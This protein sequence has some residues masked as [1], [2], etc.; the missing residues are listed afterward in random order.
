MGFYIQYSC[1]ECGYKSKELIDPLGIPSL[2][3]CS[4]NDCHAMFHR[5]IDPDDNPVNICP[6]CG[7]ENIEIHEDVRPIQCPECGRIE[8]DLECT[9]T[10]F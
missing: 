1:P 10:F 9:G 6:E 5:K 3:I 8:M 2:Y 4:C 7:G